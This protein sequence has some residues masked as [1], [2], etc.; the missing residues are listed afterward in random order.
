MEF[1]TILLA[2]TPKPFAPDTTCETDC[3]SGQITCTVEKG[4]VSRS[5][6]WPDHHVQVTWSYKHDITNCEVEEG[7]LAYTW[8]GYVASCFVLS[9][10]VINRWS[11][12][13]VCFCPLVTIVPYN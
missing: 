11:L 13:P 12:V 2:V 3:P 7:C 4:H 10:L 9:F 8:D 5:R 6:V 1:I